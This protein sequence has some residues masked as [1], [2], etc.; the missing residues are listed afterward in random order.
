[1]IIINPTNVI[2]YDICNPYS[3]LLLDKIARSLSYSQSSQ[4]KMFDFCALSLSSVMLRLPS[5]SRALAGAAKG[6]LAPSNNGKDCVCTLKL[7]G[8]I[9]VF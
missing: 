7:L 1:M 2:C 5:V 3:E 8:Y 9:H 4:I 6:S